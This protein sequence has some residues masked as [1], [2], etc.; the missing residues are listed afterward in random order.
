MEKIELIEPALDKYLFEKKEY[1]GEYGE[2]PEIRGENLAQ[3]W[4]KIGKEIG[5]EWEKKIE[6]LFNIEKL[7]DHRRKWLE[8]VGWTK[9]ET[10]KAPEKISYPEDNCLVL[11]IEVA[12]TEGDYPTMAVAMGKEA[13]YIWLSPQLF[14][15]SSENLIPLGDRTKEKL[16]VI[17]HNIIGYDR[18]RIKE[19]YQLG[20]S[21]I[22]FLDTLSMHVAIAGLS[23]KQRLSYL[24]HQK[25]EEGGYNE[26]WMS[27]GAMNNLKDVASRHLGINMDKSIRE[28][29]VTGTI[30]EIRNN[31]ERLIN[32][33]ITDVLVT[34]KL[35]KVLWA[36]FKEKSP[37][38]VT[39]SA[40]FL[41]SKMYLPTTREKWF[42]Y[43]NSAEKEYQRQSQEIEKSLHELAKLAI[44]QYE[45]NPEEVKKDKWLSQLDWTYPSKRVKIL[46]DKPEWYRKLREVKT[47]KIK[48]TTKSQITPYLLKL[49]WENYPLK[50]YPELGWG[51]IVKKED[52]YETNNIGYVLDE[53]LKLIP[54]ES[55]EL[56]LTTEKRGALVGRKYIFYKIPH[57]DG[58]KAN[59]GCVLSKDYIKEIETETLTSEYEEGKQAIY[60]AVSSSYW[61]SIRKRIK[62]QFLVVPEELRI[63]KTA[64]IEGGEKVENPDA[65]IIPS[66]IPI[67]TVS[68]RATENTWLTASNP[69]ENKIGSELKTTVEAPEGYK[70]VGGDISSQEAWIASL[71]G[72]SYEQNKLPKEGKIE[73]ERMLKG[74]KWIPNGKVGVTEFSR[75]VLKGE[76]SKKTDIHSSTTEIVKTHTK[77]ITGKE[78]KVNREDCKQLNYCVPLT[79]QALT[80]KG[81]KNY[82]E[83]KEGEIVMGYN[84][85]T[86]K[87]EWTKIKEKVYFKEAETYEIKNQEFQF[88]CTLNHNWVSNKNEIIE[89]EKIDKN[90]RIKVS[91]VSNLKKENEYTEEEIKL[92]AWVITNGYLRDSKL[93]KSKTGERKIIAMITLPNENKEN[94]E[95]LEKILK[96]LE[97]PFSPVINRIKNKKKSWYIESEKNKFRQILEKAKI[98]TEKADYTEFI[99]SLSTEQIEIFIETIKKGKIEIY[100]RDEKKIEAIK[101]ASHLNGQKIIEKK[102][103]EYTKI[104]IKRYNTISGETLEKKYHSKQDVWCLVTETGTWVMRQKGKITITG[105]SRYYGAGLKSTALYIRQIDKQLSSKEA[106]KIAKVLFQETK[107]EKLYNNG[108]GTKMWQ[109]GSESEMFNALEE[110]ANKNIPTTPFLQSAL[111]NALLPMNDKSNSY[112]TSRINWVVQSSGVDFLHMMLVGIEYLFRKDKI[113]GRLCITIH[114]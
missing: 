84:T 32:Y 5:E 13:I 99:L 105:N 59:C 111:S 107:G 19:E 4:E 18:A 69:K 31:L 16:I 7:P 71:L 63:K 26:K 106:T 20:E 61:I 65:V 89:T 43:I 30:Q 55:E 21:G 112:V 28:I 102:G 91:S 100:S 57:K 36:K 85:K 9:Y 52:N 53:N 101:L 22:Y 50:H 54:E 47:N 82:E 70:I 73:K 15:G 75:Q 34:A 94:Q 10:G 113:E 86:G 90:K 8:Q 72:D 37:H 45:E 80:P 92:I 23:T 33:N 98:S 40:I 24:K 83:L 103:K 66:L 81:W 42:N 56:V 97:I 114:D 49:K 2:L 1:K 14:G 38:P 46:K 29:F 60:C 48:I 88:I 6:E 78:T 3:H 68:R 77:K 64:L 76:K 27:E 109:G 25:E 87:Q 110:I 62:S 11:D 39:R 95:E 108:T 67:G 51:Y 74:L 44:K 41:M 17:G 93:G 96:N 58:E 35:A 12:V 79:S 104:T